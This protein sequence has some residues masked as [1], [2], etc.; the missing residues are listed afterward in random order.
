LNQNEKKSTFCII[1]AAISIIFAAN[2]ALS[3]EIIAAMTG[4]T[5][6]CSSLVVGAW[7]ERKEKDIK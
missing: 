6:G 1:L 7:Y 2:A 4:I 5:L 3:C